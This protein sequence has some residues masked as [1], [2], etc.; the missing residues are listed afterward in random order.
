MAY[1]ELMNKVRY[2]DNMT[3]RWIMRHFYLLFFQFVLVFIFILWFINTLNVVDLSFQKSGLSRL[4]R[5]SLGQTVNSTLLVLLV[6]FNSFWTLYI[7]SAILRM[8]SILRD[9]SYNTSKLKKS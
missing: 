1:K 7:L 3:A 9:I 4:E 6:L 2:W 8:R 5:I